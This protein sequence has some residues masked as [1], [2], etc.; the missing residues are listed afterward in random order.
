MAKNKIGF[1]LLGII[2]LSFFLFSCKKDIKQEITSN[3]SPTP[4]PNPLP[5]GTSSQVNDVAFQKNAGLLFM[6]YTIACNAKYIK[7]YRSDRCDD[8]NKT[9]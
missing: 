3:I 4:P 5:V 6:E 8:R 1:Q 9:I 7:L 2:F